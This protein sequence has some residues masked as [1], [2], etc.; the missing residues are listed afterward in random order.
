[1][2]DWRDSPTVRGVRAWE[3]KDNGECVMTLEDFVNL[4]YNAAVR[5]YQTGRMRLLTDEETYLKGEATALDATVLLLQRQ[6]SLRNADQLSRAEANR[7]EIRAGVRPAKTRTGK[8]KGVYFTNRGWVARVEAGGK[9]V[10][11]GYFKDPR[12][13]ALAWDAYVREHYPGRATNADL[14]LLSEEG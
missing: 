5:L 1:M 8:Y 14:G 9:K 7:R 10:L 6:L 13:G 11:L 3:H 2:P 12:E 4:N